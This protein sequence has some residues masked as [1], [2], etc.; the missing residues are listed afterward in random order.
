M[1]SSSPPSSSPSSSSSSSSSDVSGSG[2]GHYLTSEQ[3][4]KL[5]SLINEKS[6]IFEGTSVSA[7]VAGIP[8][9]RSYNSTINHD[10]VDVSKLNL[11]VNHQNG[12]F[13]KDWQNWELIVFRKA[14]TLLMSLLF[15]IFM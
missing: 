14:N 3:Y 9:F 1:N 15:L 10:I 4:N 13:A 12:T 11:L 8:L 2:G 6:S 5:L 7:N